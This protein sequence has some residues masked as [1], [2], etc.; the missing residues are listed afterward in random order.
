MECDD[1]VICP[2]GLRLFPSSP[3]SSGR[4]G[5]RD[6][7]GIQSHTKDT[8]HDSSSMYVLVSTAAWR[9]SVRPTA[10]ELSGYTVIGLVVL[11]SHQWEFLKS[12]KERCFFRECRGICLL[13]TPLLGI[14]TSTLHPFPR[15][16]K[17]SGVLIASQSGPRLSLWST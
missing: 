5:Y 17:Q 2:A 13:H 10:T 7:T 1:G 9:L 12:G 4:P 11:V 15:R 14:G 16:R 6:R 3:E 8:S